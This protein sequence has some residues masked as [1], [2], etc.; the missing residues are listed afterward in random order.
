MPVNDIPWGSSPATHHIHSTKKSYG[1]DEAK[2]KKLT[3]NPKQR[4]G[5]PHHDGSRSH[6]FNPM[7]NYDRR[8]QVGEMTHQPK[9]GRFK[10]LDVIKVT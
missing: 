7:D 2:K 3:I 8:E 9:D 6:S 10:S 4:R 5:N 1:L